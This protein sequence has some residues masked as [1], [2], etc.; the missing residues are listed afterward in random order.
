MYMLDTNIC[1]YI[2]KRKPIS[3][4]E[5]LRTL[6]PG[7]VCMSLVTL[8]ELE[9]GALRSNN[10]AGALSVLKRLGEHIPVLG[11]EASV[12]THYAQIRANLAVRGTAICNNDLWIAAHAQATG[13]T[14]VTNNLR[15]FERVESLT[16]Q[17]WA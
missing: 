13:A 8:G 15:E 2:M 16:L 9:Y 3:V 5:R 12:A 17:N 4:L 6:A 7:S 11:L 14:L 1:I 10:T